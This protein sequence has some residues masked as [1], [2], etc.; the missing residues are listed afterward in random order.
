MIILIS[1]AAFAFTFLGGAFALHFK[2]KLHLI[3]GFSAGAVIG[4]AFFEYLDAPVKRVGSL[5]TPIPMAMDLEDNFLA[6][7]QLLTVIMDLL[8]Y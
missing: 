6:K 7:K 3:L 4:V 2:D 1:L 5:D 8:E